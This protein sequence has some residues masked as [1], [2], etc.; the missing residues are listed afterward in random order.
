MVRPA[1]DM[2]AWNRSGVAEMPRTIG[3]GG[4]WVPMLVVPPLTIVPAMER[5][6]LEVTPEP[7]CAS[8]QTTRKSLPRSRTVFAIMSQAP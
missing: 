3:A 6:S 4:C 5:R 8:S 7:R 2:A 1:A